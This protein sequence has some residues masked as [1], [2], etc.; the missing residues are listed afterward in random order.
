MERENIIGYIVRGKCSITYC[1]RTIYLSANSTFIKETQETQ[2]NKLHTSKRK[3]QKVS[4]AAWQNPVTLFF[5]DFEL[6]PFFR[7]SGPGKLKNTVT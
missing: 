6:S 3:K 5:G 7:L 4:L 1:C 2:K